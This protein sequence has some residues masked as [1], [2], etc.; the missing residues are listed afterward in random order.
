MNNIIW[1][2]SAE[3]S[4]ELELFI[5]EVFLRK[6]KR[7]LFSTLFT[8][9]S[10]ELPCDLFE[11]AEKRAAESFAFALLARGPRFSSQL[12]E[13]MEQQLI[14]REAALHAAQVCEERG[15]LNDH[16]LMIRFAERKS[17][18]SLRYI[19]GLLRTKTG[20]KPEDIRRIL[21]KNMP[22]PAITIRSL[23]EKKY[24]KV[25]LSCAKARNKL[26]QALLRRGFDFTAIRSALT[27]D[28]DYRTR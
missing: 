27:S 17:D 25:D 24:R 10:G 20:L 7:K 9:D 21:A 13:K 2:T 12:I 15:Y 4:K 1:K 16:D 14:S 26:F 22:D 18:R 23:L 3:D 19:V 6:V 8:Q 28:T 5:G 11:S